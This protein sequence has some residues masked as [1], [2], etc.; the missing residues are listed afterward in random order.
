MLPVLQ[1][2]T[3][4]PLDRVNPDA[5]PFRWPLLIWMIPIVAVYVIFLLQV[6]R[7]FEATDTAYYN[8][9]ISALRHGRTDLVVSNTYDLS[10]AH[11]QW[12]MYWGP[13]PI[14]FI[15]PFY[16]VSH[17]G[18]SDV[19]YGFVAGLLNVVVF[20]GCTTELIRLFRLPVSR[21][22]QVFVILN[23]ALASP[24][25]YSSLG[26]QIWYVNQ[27]IAVLYLLVFLYFTLKFLQDQ[28]L[29]H[30]ALAAL[31]FNLAWNSRLSLVFYGLL[32]VYVLAKLAMTNRRVLL[33]AAGVIVVVT[34]LGL[35]GFF[36]Y[37]N[38]RFSSP[39]EIGY[40]YQI[41][42]PKYAADFAANRLFSLSHVPHNATYYFLNPVKLSFEPPY[43]QIDP[44]G[45]SIFSVYPL[46]FFGYFFAT[47][48]TYTRANRWFFVALGAALTINFGVILLNLGTGWYQFGSRYFFDVV[49]GL[50]LLILFV[51]ER[52]NQPLKALLLTYGAFV[53]LVGALL[54]YHS[55]Q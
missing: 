15:L 5:R 38:A 55:L 43:V 37:N 7:T 47:R 3:A 48:N 52:V 31:F 21:F 50:F 54:Y 4:G 36:A 27:V 19:V 13:A 53:N 14:L 34:L 17:L 25:F 51:V 28:K 12:Y 32:L 40:R 16:V 26:G 30:I 46:V 22:S 18:A 49:P 41:P 20:A 35:G 44:E 11:G 33:Q 8:Y 6:H 45:N 2:S 1:R 39:F 23:F 9:L 10:S 24:N 29:T 42:N